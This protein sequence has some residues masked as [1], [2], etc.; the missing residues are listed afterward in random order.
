MLVG[1]A[2]KM[3]VYLVGP[4]SPYA[5]MTQ[6]QIQQAAFSNGNTATGLD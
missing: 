4:S 2:H 3:N 5:T 6:S 1:A